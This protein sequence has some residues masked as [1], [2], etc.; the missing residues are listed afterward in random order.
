MLCGN[1]YCIYYVNLL[2]IALCIMLKC[3]PKGEVFSIQRFGNKVHAL[4]LGMQEKFAN[5]YMQNNLGMTYM[6]GDFVCETDGNVG[7]KHR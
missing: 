7:A 6:I 2:Y 5:I 4:L 3:S 1:L